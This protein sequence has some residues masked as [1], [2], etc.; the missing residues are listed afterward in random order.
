MTRRQGNRGVGVTDRDEGKLRTSLVRVV[1]LAQ[2]VVAFA[3]TSTVAP[4]FDA[5]VRPHS[6]VPLGSP[7]PKKT[8]YP[9][10]R[11]RPLVSPDRVVI[12]PVSN[13]GHR[14][15]FGVHPWFYPSS[16]GTPLPPGPAPTQNFSSDQ[17]LSSE[18]APTTENPK[19]GEK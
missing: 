18:E 10:F 8:S 19:L 2:A 15:L 14:S 13:L 12:L 5:P 3:P 7:T 1:T 17:K 11:R 9:P 6:S 16:P 4:S